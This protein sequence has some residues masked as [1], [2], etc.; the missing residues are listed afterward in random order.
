MFGSQF[1]LILGSLQWRSSR[2]RIRELGSDSSMV[3]FQF[4][5]CFRWWSSGVS[6][7]G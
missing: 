6:D 7:C 5:W 2:V 1:A 3:Q 4:W